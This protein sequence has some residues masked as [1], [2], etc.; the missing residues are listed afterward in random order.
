[1]PGLVLAAIAAVALAL[2]SAGAPQVGEAPPPAVVTPP[3][4]QPPFRGV[5]APTVDQ[6]QPAWNL[7]PRAPE[8]APNILA[9]MLDDIGFAH[10]GCYGAPIDTP[11]IDALARSGLRYSNFHATPLCSPS[12]AAFLT[13]RNHH[14]CALGVIAE[15][16]TGFPGYNGRMPLSHGMLSEVLGPAGWSTFA[17]GKWHLT[18]PEDANLAA[19][20]RGWPL[21]RGFDRYYGFL[22]GTTSR[23]VPWLTHDNHFVRPPGTPEEGY[24]LLTDMTGKAREYILD[25]KHVAPDR[26]FFMYFAPGGCRAPQQVPAEWIERYRGRFD[27]GWDEYP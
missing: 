18:P 11:N 12:R 16:S 9:V 20:R 2:P 1:M 5:I 23:W 8:G 4:T 27:G 19:T 13:G 25:V 21:G 14:S 3:P 17:L 15:F 24:H 22:G 7:L 6:A 26:P 10:L